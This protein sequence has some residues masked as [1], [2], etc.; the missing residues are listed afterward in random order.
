MRCSSTASRRCLQAL[1]NH[2]TVELAA[3]TVGM[4]ALKL[5]HGDLAALVECAHAAHQVGD[6]LIVKVMAIAVG[7]AVVLPANEV[8]EFDSVFLICDS[9]RTFLLEN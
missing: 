8:V 3:A 4:E 7:V 9:H 5:A 2:I 1:E 6:L